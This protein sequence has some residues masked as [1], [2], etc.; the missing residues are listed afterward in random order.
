MQVRVYAVRRSDCMK[1]VS[2]LLFLTILGSSFASEIRIIADFRG[3]TPPKRAMR[4]IK[5]PC[6]LSNSAGLEFDLR[7][8]R[9]DEYSMFT[10]HFDCDGKWVGTK[11]KPSVEGKWERIAVKKPDT[12]VAGRDWSKVRGFRISGWRGGTNHTFMTVRNISVAQSIEKKSLSKAEID[13]ANRSALEKLSASRALTSE[14]RLVWAHKPIGIKGKDWDYCAQILKKGGFTDLVANLTRGTRAAY[15]SEVLAFAETAEGRDCLQ[16]CLAA[17]RKYGLKL[18]VWNCCWRT[19]WGTTAAEFEKLASEGRLQYSD[20]GEQKKEWLCPSHPANRKMLVDSMVEAAKKGVDGVH[21]DYI[22]YPDG[23][24]CFCKGCKDRF[25]AKIGKKLTGW[26]KCLHK[27]VA[28]NRQWREFRRD[29]ITA[30][31]KEVSELVHRECPDVEVSAAV[32]M[33]PLADGDWVGQDWSS[34]C[35]KGYLDFVCPMTYENDL[36]AF[37][38]R[39]RHIKSVLN[40]KV[41]RYPG[42]GL[43]V[44]PKDGLDISRFADQIAYLREY[45]ADGFSVFELSPRLVRLIEGIPSL[46]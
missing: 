22:R 32:F 21:F 44:W 15:R 37:V 9:L 35:E 36:P 30:P 1:Q 46:Q 24:Y 26:P 29:T 45:G 25:E 20:F 11:M 12:E 8:D 16:E 42:I 39:Q 23:S 3:E 28:L 13:A 10:F 7:V 38:R 6:D 17:C 4:D 27:D 33:T 2:I 19:G 31:V 41:P 34:W 40:N 43:G 5:F 18:H 14:R